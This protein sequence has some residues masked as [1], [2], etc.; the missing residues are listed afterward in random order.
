MTQIYHFDQIDDLQLAEIARQIQAGAVVVFPTD[1]VYGIG[2]NAFDERAIA[3]IYQV[4]Q[5]PPSAAL[6]ILVGAV[7][8]AKEIVKWDERADR[9]AKAYWPGALTMI[10]S[11][12]EKGACLRRGFAG[13]GL[14]VPGHKQLV[15]LLAA[16]SVPLASTS[17]NLH[18]QPVL[19]N[20]EQVQEAFGGKV[21]ILILGGTLSAVASS[22]IDLTGQVRILREGAIK[23][24]SL[25]EI[26]KTAEK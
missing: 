11:S 18:G 22:V 14:R 23:Q 19:T 26:L 15:K 20:E 6:Q 9:L 3:R 2:A 12:N 10:L 4:K 7:S 1:T 24:S 13:L 8:Q 25:M 17:A 5:R 16:L 21:D